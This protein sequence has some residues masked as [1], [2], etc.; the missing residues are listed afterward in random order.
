VVLTHE[1]LGGR[2]LAERPAMVTIAERS[3]FAARV[4]VW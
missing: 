4:G 1:L 2:V 3:V